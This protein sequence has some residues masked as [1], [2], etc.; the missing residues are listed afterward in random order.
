MNIIIL[1]APNR[2]NRYLI[3]RIVASYPSYNVG[4]FEYSMANKKSKV[5]RRFLSRYSD[6]K[7]LNYRSKYHFVRYVLRELTENLSVYLAL[8]CYMRR[9]K[10]SENN[11]TALS[12]VS[13]DMATFHGVVK[14]WDSLDRTIDSIIDKSQTN[15]LL[16][17]G[18]PIIPKLIFSK[19]TYAI[20]QHAGVSPAYKGSLTNEQALFRRDVDRIGSTV[21]LISSEVD[22]GSILKQG[23]VALKGDDEPSDIFVRSVMLG[24]E[25]MVAVLDEYARNG[26]F[27]VISSNS[28]NES[29]FRSSDFDWNVYR[30]IHSNTFKRWFKK[31]V[32]QRSNG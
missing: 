3:D 30:S 22:G 19:F 13:L 23:R 28:C 10:I 9:I 26:N 21:H 24:T 8:N 4:Y 6:V 17:S 32:K 14:D 18:G 27:N 16:V 11:S 29:I 12:K 2:R 5:L 25:L 20:N 15:F 7:N 1:V 31:Q